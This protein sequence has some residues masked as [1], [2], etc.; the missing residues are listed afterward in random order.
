MSQPE[1]LD[2]LWSVGRA[3]PG[4]AAKLMAIVA[5]FE[6]PVREP[7]V[8]GELQD[9][10]TGFHPGDLGGNGLRVT[11]PGMA[12]AVKPCHLA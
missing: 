12:I 11:L 6:G 2:L 1:R 3:V 4:E 8:T 9:F 5:G 10:S 7:V